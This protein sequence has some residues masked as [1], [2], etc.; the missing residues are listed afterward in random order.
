M[1]EPITTVAFPAIGTKVPYGQ[2]DVPLPATGLGAPESEDDKSSSNATTNP[3]PA[4]LLK[5][6]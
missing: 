1:S 3:I 2:E 4:F 5:R 6:D